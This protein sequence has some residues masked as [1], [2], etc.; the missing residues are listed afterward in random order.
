MIMP[1]AVYVYVCCTS[2]VACLQAEMGA[3]REDIAPTWLQEP[4]SLEETA[5]KYV[6]PHLR[7]IFV[8]LCRQPVSQYLDRLV[9][10][11]TAAQVL[12]LC[13]QSSLFVS[14]LPM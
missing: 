7:N 2:G 9:T 10:V 11:G 8:D 13:V 14:I 5:E 3:L 6:R 12:A 1:P 4:L